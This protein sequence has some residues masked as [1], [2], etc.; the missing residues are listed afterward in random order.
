MW[1]GKG[2]KQR[3]PRIVEMRVGRGLVSRSWRRW[4]VG[5]GEDGMLVV[6]KMACWWW[7]VQRGIAVEEEKHARGT[8]IDLA[9]FPNHSAQVAPGW[10]GR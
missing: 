10:T 2:H 1:G 3:C 5:R 4:H 9:D 7:H 8:G 6:K